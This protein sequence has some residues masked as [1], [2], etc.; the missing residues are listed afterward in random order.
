MELPE[1]ALADRRHGVTESAVR[2]ALDTIVDPCSVIAGAPGGL[3]EMGLVRAVEIIETP[4]GAQ[5]DVTI[6][7]T[8]PTCLMGAVFL[9]DAEAALRSL[10]GVAAVAVHLDPTLRYDVSMQQPDYAARL[11]AAR[12]RRNVTIGRTS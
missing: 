11:R 12:Q 9:R 8:E 2:A 10:P 4:G 6:G 1:L 5:V 3:D 7:V